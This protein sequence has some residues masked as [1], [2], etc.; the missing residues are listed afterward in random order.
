MEKN[1]PTEDESSEPTIKKILLS[2][3][4]EDYGLLEQAASLEKLNKTEILRRGLRRYAKELG[5]TN[6]PPIV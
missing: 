2:L 3:D 4:L 6:T 1:D 5:V